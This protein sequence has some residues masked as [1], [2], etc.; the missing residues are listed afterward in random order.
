MKPIALIPAR[1]GSKRLPRKNIMPFMGSPLL[2]WPIRAAIESEVFERVIVSTED[3]EIANVAIDSGA[4]VVMRSA[5]LATDTATVAQTCINALSVLTGVQDLCC[6]YATAALLEPSDIV[7]SYQ[8]YVSKSFDSVMGVAKY[9]LS[10]L[11]ALEEIDGRWRLRWPEFRSVQSQNYPLLLCSA[12]MFYWV[13]ADALLCERSFYT[14]N[15]GVFE[16]PRSR[17][18]DINTL[19][20]FIRVEEVAKQL[21]KFY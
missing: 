5:E 13:K 9:D 7:N 4:E 21:V 3:N 12:G 15:M 14:Q 6:I 17:L 16:I 1:G 2:H 18:C 11:Q 19:E 10:P 20:D 8:S